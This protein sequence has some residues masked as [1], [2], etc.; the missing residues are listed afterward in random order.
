MKYFIQEL[1]HLKDSGVECGWGNGYVVIP[2]EHPLYNVQCENMDVEVHGG[3]TLSKK[4]TNGT[5]ELF[6]AL[7]VSDLGC[8][9]VGFDTA[10]YGDDG[11]K[12]SMEAVQMETERLVL[13]LENY[14]KKLTE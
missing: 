6:P 2:P 8:W 11:Y 4:I 13:Q 5:L 7:D 1:T 9:L 14:T 12:W 10:H 3:L